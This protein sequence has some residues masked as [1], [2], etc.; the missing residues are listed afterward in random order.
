MI[1]EKKILAH[2]IGG[3]IRLLRKSKGMS[4]EKLAYKSDIGYV[5][6]S[7]I[8]LGKI[9]TTIYQVFRISQSLEVELNEL[10][11]LNNSK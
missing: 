9:N 6:L 8:E 1:D 2:K 3:N 4:I 7:R 11:I 10:F 5:Q